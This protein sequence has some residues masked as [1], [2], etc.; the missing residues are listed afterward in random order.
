MLLQG[1]ESMKSTPAKPFLS[2]VQTLRSR[3]RH[4]MEFGRTDADSD[5][6]RRLVL[7]ILNQAL[8]TE[9]VC[10]LRYKNHY[11]NACGIESPAVADDFLEHAEQEEDHADRIAERIVQLGGRPDFNPGG[12]LLRSHTEFGGDFSDDLSLRSLIEEDLLAE[13]VAIEGYREIVQ[14]LS[15]EGDHDP[16]TRCLM[17]SL[18]A[19]EERH[20]ADL[21]RMLRQTG[22]HVLIASGAA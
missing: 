21:A 14:F 12:L 20:A 8:A 9:L 5:D 22:G 16:T 15:S 4:Q 19:D 18:L 2:D 11:F 7:E 10:I 1:C 13:R 3:A 6:R 17:E